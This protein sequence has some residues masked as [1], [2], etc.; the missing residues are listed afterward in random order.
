MVAGRRRRVASGS[1]DKTVRL[2]EAATGRRGAHAGGPQRRGLSVAWSPD[3]RA[4]ASGSYD[5]TVRLWDA[6][7]GRE[8]LSLEGHQCS[9]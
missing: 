6:A 3:G 5:K 1:D 4:L 8:R 7:S 2:W 9:Y